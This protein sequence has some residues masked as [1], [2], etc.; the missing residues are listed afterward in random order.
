MTFTAR[1]W[2]RFGRGMLLRGVIVLLATLAP[3]F[4]A[5]S[6][7][8]DGAPADVV[9]DAAA[10]PRRGIGEM[11]PLPS[12]YESETRGERLWEY[13][14]AAREE[15]RALMEHAP[16]DW[17]DIESD[18]GKPIDPRMRI[19]VVLNPDHLRELAPRGL[20]PPAYAV[21]VAYPRLGV[22]L[23][24]LT[25][26]DT[27]RRPPMDV[28]LSHELS[29]V[30]LHR[31]V[32]GAPVPRWFTEGVA[33]EHAKEFTLDRYQTLLEAAIG[34]SL[35]PLD[36]LSGAF[37]N[38]PYAVN[39]AYAESASFVHFLR[40][41]RFEARRFRALVSNLAAGTEFPKAVAASYGAPLAL[42]EQEWR[43]SLDEQFR[44][45][46]LLLG[47]TLAW[48]LAAGLLAL[49][50]VKLRRRH[51]TRL[52]AWGVREAAEQKAREAAERQALELAAAMAAR[53]EDGGTAATRG[54][55]PPDMKHVV[56]RPRESGIP[57]VV[58]DGKPHT[59]H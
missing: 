53:G 31:A 2:A 52:E 36:D 42:L 34:R 8:A 29:H 15:A 54:T 1:A 18:L 9:S 6:A 45:W 51:R 25:A 38:R 5:T 56:E 47:G 55:I 32:N 35:L 13:P 46:P 3:V 12:D 30:A 27:W 16:Q 44:A 10:D 58:H 23:L 39:V 11:P 57:T 43:A 4:T 22:I 33:I 7:L 19:R 48:A 50:F 14:K 37:P 21:G 20:P 59:L 41:N 17:D 40:G 24:S 26:P 49:A 28:V